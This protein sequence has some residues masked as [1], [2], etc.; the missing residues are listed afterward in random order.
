MRHSLPV[1]MRLAG[2]A[3]PRAQELC[4]SRGGHSGLP[5]PNTPDGFCG[6]KAPPKKKKS[7][8]PNS[9]WD[10]RNSKWATRSC[11]TV[12][13]NKPKLTS[14]FSPWREAKVWIKRGRLVKVRGSV[15]VS[16]VCIHN[17]SHCA[18]LKLKH[19]PF[20]ET[21]LVLTPRKSPSTAVLGQVINWKWDERIF[22]ITV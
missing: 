3:I 19:S 20:H 4:E 21:D 14:F 5:V 9:V 17:I 12:R 22:L 16:D 8:M 13:S 15:W 6:R 10:W 18:V 1:Y 2:S 7:A 11:R